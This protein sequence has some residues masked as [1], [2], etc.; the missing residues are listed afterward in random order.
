MITS[1]RA[2]FLPRTR[3]A[4]AR[5][6]RRSS[7][8]QGV[9]TDRDIRQALE[10]GDL[11]VDPFESDLVGP[12]AIGLRL[13]YRAFSLEASDVVD[14]ADR[15]SYPELRP[16]PLDEQGRLRIEPG[17]VV[18]A[19]TLEQVGLSERLVGLVDG[20]SDYA[21]LGVGVVLRSQVG[22]GFGQGRGAM[23]TLEIVSHLKQA[24][25]LHPG[26]RIC[27]LMLFAS[28]GSGVASAA[29]QVNHAPGYAATPSRVRVPAP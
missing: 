17:E 8:W 14:I 16:K 23:I 5:V 20:T 6:E 21:R 29:V 25:L 9:L 7:A 15:S 18:L 26:S 2:L 11:S 24:V 12:A 4:K 28:G 1:M 3:R 19:P 10:S 22:P 27:N 13:G